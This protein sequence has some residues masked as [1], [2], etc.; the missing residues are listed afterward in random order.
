MND[1]AGVGA[2][3]KKARASVDQNCVEV[4]LGDEA[5]LVRDTKD[6]EQGP[7]LR[8]TRAEWTAFLTGVR[9]GEFN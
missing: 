8:F 4:C 1:G 3:W 2:A 5:V 6:Q 7:I 9:A